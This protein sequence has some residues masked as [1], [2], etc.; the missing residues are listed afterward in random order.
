VRSVDIKTA[1]SIM[2]HA[3]AEM[4][5]CYAD[6]ELDQVRGAIGAINHGFGA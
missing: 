2:G 3:S 5:M 1:Q 4:T 6:T